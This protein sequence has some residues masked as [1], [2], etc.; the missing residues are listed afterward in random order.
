[1]SPKAPLA[2]AALL[3]ASLV[4]ASSAI[5]AP[6]FRSSSSVSTAAA[7]G[8]LTLPAPAGVAAGDVMIAGIEARITYSIAVTAPAGWTLVRREASALPINQLL[9]YRIAG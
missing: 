7:V 1:M 4:L 6:N 9:Y 8:S 3:V 5:A 2:T